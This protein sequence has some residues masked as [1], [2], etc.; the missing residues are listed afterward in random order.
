V[1]QA[2][3]D[4]LRVRLAALDLR[5][6]RMEVLSSNIANADTPHYK[7]R[8][9]DFAQAL[10]SAIA[11][12]QAKIGMVRTDAGHLAGRGAR[13]LPVALQYR[14]PT[15]PSIDGNTVEMDRELGQ[16]SDNALRYQA[17]L[18]FLNQRIAGLR[19]AITG[20]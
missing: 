7:A 18:T 10:R 2:I 12:T 15:Q 3:D 14:V 17:S 16:F 19:T 9:F 6:Q 11:G 5:A 1:L 8:D 13:D 20:Q 4:H